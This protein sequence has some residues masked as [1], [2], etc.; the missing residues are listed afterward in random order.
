MAHCVLCGCSFNDLVARLRAKAVIRA[1]RAFLQRVHYLSLI[2]DNEEQKAKALA[3]EPVPRLTFS[4]RLSV[5]GRSLVSRAARIWPARTSAAAPADAVTMVKS[6][7]SVN[8]R[9][10]LASYMI[11]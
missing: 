4:E 11:R 8:V 7:K 10:F 3:A 6:P 5:F 1:A 9:V 2:F